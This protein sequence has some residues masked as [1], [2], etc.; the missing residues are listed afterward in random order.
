MK[1][2]LFFILIFITTFT[3]AQA[4]DSLS[5]LEQVVST[6]V[7]KLTS[8]YPNDANRSLAIPVVIGNVQ[9]SGKKAQ[10]L[11]MGKALK[12]VLSTVFS[13]SRV[14]TVLERDNLERI[15]K[16][17]ELQL[18]GLTQTSN[19]VGFGK[20]INAEVLVTASVVEQEQG[21]MVTITLSTL[22]SGKALSDSMFV[23]KKVFTN[24]AEERLD[25]LYVAPMGIGISLGGMAVTSSGNNATLNPFP[26]MNKTFSRKNMSAEV[27]YRFTD[28]LMFGLG[29][30][31][32][33]GHAWTGTVGWANLPAPHNTSTGNAPFTIIGKGIGIPFTLYGN[34][35]PVRW[36]S[37]VVSAQAEICVMDY[38]GYFS[39]SE[40]RGFGDN[41]FG[42]SMHQEFLT[43]T[44]QAGAEVFITPRLSFSLMA[45][46]NLGAT[47]LS[48]SVQKHLTNLPGTINA[49][50]EGFTLTPRFTVYF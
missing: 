32:L 33:Y 22:E 15:V 14:F 17:L 44:F 34:Y 29:I 40:G 6:M 31:W 1:V 13:R 24:V 16:E 39:P 12:D 20:L 11:Q 41:E 30:D 42:P 47:D 46:Y 19:S 26:E 36:L 7:T 18:T 4:Q 45:G 2:R 38:H 25:K 9:E 10:E 49:S 28:F 5:V 50:Y 35:N 48:M 8:L 37:L 3:F 27:R 43:A 21:F 23:D